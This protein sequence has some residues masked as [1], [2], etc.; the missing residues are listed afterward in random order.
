MKRSIIKIAYKAHFQFNT[1]HSTLNIKH[2]FLLLLSLSPLL[3]SSPSHAQAFNRIEW[4]DVDSL[5]SVLPGQQGKERLQTLNFLAASLSFEDKKESENYA[6]QALE[7]AMQL[8]DRKGEAEAFR[9]LARKEFYDGN[10]P[11]ALNFYQQS[12]K[13]YEATGDRYRVA[14][15][16][17][18][19]AVTHFFAGNYNKTF[20][21]IHLALDIYREKNTDGTTVG[22]VTDT[23]AIYSAA[24]LPYRLTGQSDTALK[25]YLNY[26]EIGKKNHFEITDIMLHHGLVAMCYFEN[27]NYDSALFYLRKA[28]EFPEVN[29]SIQA[30]K[31][32]HIGY[33]G[34]VY[35]EQ[36]MIDSA[37]RM[38]R[39][40]FEWFSER[41]FLKQ[42]QMDAGLLGD[43]YHSMGK[44]HEAEKYYII[45]EE[46]LNEMLSKHSYY[47]YDSLKYVVSWGRELFFPFTKKDVKE[48]TYTSAVQ[49]YNSMYSFYNEKKDLLKAMNYLE[50]CSA[51]KDTL[52]NLERN[53]ESIEI[54]TK[55]ETERKDA[56][57]L[58]L[59]QQ[60]EL[61]EIRLR[62]SRGFLIGLGGIVILIILLAAILIRQ[63]RLR[64]AQEKL[65]IQ[66]KLL[67]SQMNPHFLFNSLTSIQNYMNRDKDGMAGIYL[68]KFSKL[69]RQILK[70]SSQ[71][72]VTLEEEINTIE[73]YLSLQKIRFPDKFDY[74]IDID[75]DLESVLVPPMLAQPFI[76]NSIEHGFKNKE[77]KGHLNIRFSLDGNM[78][79]LEIEDDGI[80]R[81][82][83][84][85]ILEKQNKNHRSMATNITRERLEA[86]N[87]KSKKKIALEI[88]DLKD[89]N[90]EV[91]GT[92]VQF[93]IPISLGIMK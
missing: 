45:S 64:A 52:R 31:H 10:Y 59:S 18:D 81:K 55:Y 39:T 24:G 91:M 73:N 48:S 38:F 11:M 27:G 89:E 50:L 66:Q 33:M 13:I 3:P 72:Q 90:G 21:F 30:M 26:L 76:E 80:G 86:L 65:L 82:K 32:R 49:L 1:Q 78:L 87:R 77:D 34:Y 85:E 25:L 57:I 8:R 46:L 79:K 6:N 9:N 19:I 16:H 4:Y 7:L 54:Q 20:E 12:L 68:S 58:H 28:N 35:L 37:I 23:M 56:E 62:Q 60:N 83:A 93:K 14:Q 40:S 17:D 41:G 84:M 69:V 67:R 61:S 75:P 74:R 92:L 2:F 22:N 36:G 51:A 63:G 47:R 44:N 53:R 88:I 5:L 42:S 71:E 70:S 29:P 15:L 43:I